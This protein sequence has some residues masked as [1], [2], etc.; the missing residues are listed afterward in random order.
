M[1]PVGD[2]MEELAKRQDEQQRQQLEQAAASG[3]A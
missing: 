2:P 1:V 3:L